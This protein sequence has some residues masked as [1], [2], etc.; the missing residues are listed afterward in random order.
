MECDQISK[1]FLSL[2]EAGGFKV[3]PA[4]SLLHSSVP[5][6]F[7]MSAG[8]IQIENELEQIIARVGTRFSFTQPCFRHFDVKQVTH[9]SLHLSL[10]HMSAAFNMGSTD[11]ESVLPRL[12]DYLTKTLHLSKNTLWIS[13]LDDKDFGRDQQTYAC[14]Q[15]LG[16]DKKHLIGLNKQHNFWQ[17]QQSGKIA[18][19]GKKCG[20]HT[21]VFFERNDIH[22]NCDKTKSIK[23]QFLHCHCGRFVEI[24]NTL[25]IEHYINDENRLIPAQH[26]F[27]E[28]VIGIE[29][30]AM[31][32]QRVPSVY[33]ISR[34][35]PIRTALSY[36][37]SQ[38]DI[39]PLLE[40]KPDNSAFATSSTII[41]DHLS[42][43]VILINAGA[44]APGRGGRARIMRNLARAIITQ[45]LLHDLDVTLLF[46]QV[47]IEKEQQRSQSLL[48][49]EYQRFAKTLERGKRKLKALYQSQQAISSNIQ[50]EFQYK[51]GIPPCLFKKF[52]TILIAEKL[53]SSDEIINIHKQVS[54]S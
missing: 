34:F 44:P 6:S 32:L 16:V 17:Q 42:A 7:V 27:S 12:W 14:W 48:N 45:A 28:C 37:F 39:E 31:I 38:Q 51:E 15:D 30:L 47:L 11:R 40:I 50:H 46:Q 53:I 22:C 20:P 2:H 35:K 23:E 41:I 33:H 54:R 52:Q 19:D 21:E 29:R 1:A 5:M 25:F 18:F 13:Y 9:N 10:F 43:F 36:F 24:S 3:L 4:A 26:V 8:L 49:Q